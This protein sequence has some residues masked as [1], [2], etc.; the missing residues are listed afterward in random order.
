MKNNNISN[1]K[2]FNFDNI[3]WLLRD[4]EFY[5]ETV[6]ILKSKKFLTEEFGD[7]HST[8]EILKQ[9][10]NFLKHSHKGKHGLTT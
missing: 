2:I 9:F 3:Y 10:Q 7:S 6:K 8:T 5:T 1:P 4:K